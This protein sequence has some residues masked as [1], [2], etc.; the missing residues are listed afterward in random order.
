MKSVRNKIQSFARIPQF[1]FLIYFIIDGYICTV[2]ILALM[3]SLYVLILPCMPCSDAGTLTG[4]QT[5]FSISVNAEH[6]ERHNEEACNPFCICSCCGQ[7]YSPELQLHKHNSRRIYSRTEKQVIAEF[8]L[9]DAF[10]FNIW[11]PPRLC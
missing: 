9:P 7:N 11:Q 1:S 5:E 10:L 2:K 6:C 8:S 3:L 4:T